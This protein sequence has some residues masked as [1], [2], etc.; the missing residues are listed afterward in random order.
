MNAKKHDIALIRKYLN[1]E[2]DARAM[3][4]LER[5]AE[6]D[7]SLWDMIK[8]MEA[9]GKNDQ[10][11][12]NEIDA[13][14]DQ[15]VKKE[16]KRIIPLWTIL[17]VAASLFIAL[18]IGGWLLIHQA[19]K[20]VPALTVVKKPAPAIKPN[21]P[22]NL[23]KPVLPAVKPPLIAKIKP[24]HTKAELPVA[25]NTAPA[26][27]AVTYKADTIEYRASAYKVKQNAT[28]EELL[29]KM[30]GI[31]VDSKGNV[32][33]QGLQV[34][35]VKVNGKEYFGKDVTTVTKNLP[36]D[37]VDKVQVI[38]DYG[39]QTAKTGIKDGDPKKVMNIAVRGNGL[40]TGTVVDKDGKPIPGA[41]VKI[42][43]TQTAVATDANGQFKIVDPKKTE[44][45]VSSIGYLAQQVK[46]NSSD[47]LNITLPENSKAL[48]EVSIVG[49]GTQKKT[50]VV[51][52]VATI[53][54]KDLEEVK[55]PTNYGQAL[56][57]RAP[58]LSVQEDKKAKAIAV[59][60][61]IKGI[62]V[63]KNDNSP[64][65]GVMVRVKDKT[66]SAVTDINGRFT[67]TVP[68]YSE[69][70]L[71]MYIGYTTQQV[72]VKNNAELNIALSANNMALNE[73]VVTGYGTGAPVERSYESPH[74]A[75]GWHNYN[76]YI[77]D[78]ATMPDG[79]TGVVRLAFTVNKDGSI[80]N[81]VVKKGASLEMNQKAISLVKDGPGWKG[82]SDGQPKVKRL[83]I[84]FH[85]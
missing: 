62:V 16:K 39:D 31:E 70:L 63:D 61:T 33:A 23:A 26:L 18:G 27:A 82:A 47:K 20:T 76:K 32:T 28:T 29:K 12:L 56:A 36:A 77:E 51:G 71:V 5:Q 57:G 45:T 37:V 68:P 11:I 80:T 4:E 55:A 3:F 34:A 83:R 50:D 7:P 8:G 79:K 84:K 38:D 53:Q 48:A 40:I 13:L 1:G 41:S 43:G 25:A 2:L 30:E 15:R 22:Y 35:R 46:V 42:N 21:E 19:E 72:T 52:S 65:I 74:P 59:A 17:S 6:A 73:V 49:Y 24:H 14:I 85:K 67:I 60:R 81:I 9:G 54:A 66:T 44:L 64:L 78:N 69:T 58:G 10:L 75:D